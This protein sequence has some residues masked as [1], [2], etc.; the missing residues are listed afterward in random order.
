MGT[1]RGVLTFAWLFPVLLLGAIGLLGGRRWSS[2]LMWAAAVL[3][4]AALI[5]LIVFGPVFSMVQPLI[6]A[7][8]TPPAGQADVFQAM[9]L[10]K[11]SVMAQNA[12]GTF[13]GGLRI[14]TIIMLVVALALVALGFIWNRRQGEASSET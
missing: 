12:I 3:G 2:K 10:T 6:N 9:L 11:L 7:A 8:L 14:Q 13:I 5:L 4:V 1:A